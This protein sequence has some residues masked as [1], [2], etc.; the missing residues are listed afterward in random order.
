[1]GRQSLKI[2]TTTKNITTTTKTRGGGGLQEMGAGGGIRGGD[3]GGRAEAGERGEHR[4]H[5]NLAWRPQRY[6]FLS[7]GDLQLVGFRRPNNNHN[8]NHPRTNQIGRPGERGFRE[9]TGFA[10]GSHRSFPLNPP[11][12]AATATATTKRGGF[13]NLGEN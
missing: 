13:A 4:R 6:G 11:C 12:S 7:L 8:H 5:R 1:M 2:I 10:D 9:G 3:G